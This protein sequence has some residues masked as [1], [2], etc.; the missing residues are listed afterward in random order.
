MYNVNYNVFIVRILHA[1]VT[2]YLRYFNNQQSCKHTT[3]IN[4]SWKHLHVH[5]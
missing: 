1:D 2:Q 5:I 4:V 3:N